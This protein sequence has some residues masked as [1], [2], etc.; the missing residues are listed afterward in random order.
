MHVSEMV[1]A[2]YVVYV[3]LDQLVFVRKL[4]DDGEEAEKLDYNFFVALSA[5]VLNFLD[6]ILQNGRLSALMVSIEF[7]QVVNLDV[8]HDCLGEPEGSANVP[9]LADSGNTLPQSGRTVAVILAV[10]QILEVV[11][12]QLLLQ[13][14]VVEF[15]TQSKL[16]IDFFLANTELL[17]IKEADMLRSICQLLCELMLAFRSVEQAQI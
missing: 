9:W 2:L 8:V 5:E 14:Q 1:F 11:V 4:K 15:A 7:G 12:L 3:F 13:W 17:D 10:V 6:M 16:A